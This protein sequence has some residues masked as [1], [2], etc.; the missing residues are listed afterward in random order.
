MEKLK[1]L[2]KARGLTQKQLGEMC[3]VSES[4]INRIETGARKPS[5]ELTLKLS[6][7]LGC[8][9]DSL[10]GRSGLIVRRTDEPFVDVSETYDDEGNVISREENY[11]T[12]FYADNEKNVELVQLLMDLR[13]R[14]ETRMLFK[15]AHDATPE[16][17]EAAVRIIKALRN[18]E[19]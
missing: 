4:T 16:D 17:V 19:Q 11:N 14:P 1:K 12:L 15:L 10:T 9:V 13:T 5:Y 8:S 6:R 2:R 18:Q 7:A 3:G